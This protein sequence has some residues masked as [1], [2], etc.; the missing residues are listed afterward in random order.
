MEE[1]KDEGKR[2]GKKEK[3]KK[4]EVDSKWMDYCMESGKLYDYER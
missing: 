2:K 4:E 1:R 3:N